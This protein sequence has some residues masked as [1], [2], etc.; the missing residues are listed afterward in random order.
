MLIVTLAPLF[1]QSI[2]YYYAVHPPAFFG[3]KWSWTLWLARLLI[4]FLSWSKH[5]TR[6]ALRTNGMWLSRLVLSPCGM[7]GMTESSTPKSGLYNTHVYMQQICSVF[8]VSGLKTS[9]PGRFSRFGEKSCCIV[10]R[11]SACVLHLGA[12]NKLKLV[13]IPV[14]SP[15][16]GLF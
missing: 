7:L 3:A 16:S 1:S 12:P 15:A 8:G 6:L 11:P 4:F 14:T 10:N 9:A 5:S 2:T 13:L